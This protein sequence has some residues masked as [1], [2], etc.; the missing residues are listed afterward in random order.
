MRRKTMGRKTIVSFLCGILLFHVMGAAAEE[1]SKNEM[2][3]FF[4]HPFLAHMGLP[5]MPNEFSLRLTPFQER[6]GAQTSQDLKIHLEAGLLR[7]VGLHLRNEALRRAPYTEIMIMV[8]ALHN[9][10][11]SRGIGL[12][13]QIS[14]PTGPIASN[15]YKGLFGVSATETLRRFMEINAN[16]HVDLKDKMGEFES[17]FVMRASEVLF[18]VVEIQGEVHEKETL[19]SGLVGMKFRTTHRTGLG[20]GFQFPFTKAK[21]YDT[22]VL[23][24]L[25][26]AI[27]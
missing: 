14:I 23:S 11:Y 12:F 5:D 16:V 20:F 21:E 18:P 6:Y 7:N 8:A 22:R 17:A 27:E 2:E 10:E 1:E 25:E 3:H 13:G 15:Q 19:V 4:L 26:I 24:T 9:E